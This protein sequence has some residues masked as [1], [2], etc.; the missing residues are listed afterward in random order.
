MLRSS[1][2]N[3]RERIETTCLVLK[4]VLLELLLLYCFSNTGFFPKNLITSL[5]YDLEGDYSYGSS[6]FYLFSSMFFSTFISWNFGIGNNAFVL[7]FGAIYIALEKHNLGFFDLLHN[8]DT[9]LKINGTYFSVEFLTT[10]LL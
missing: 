4:S 6:R 3:C 8:L 1:L 7:W 5:L 9:I 2:V 10:T